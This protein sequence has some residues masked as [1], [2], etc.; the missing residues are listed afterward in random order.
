ME[1]Q[2]CHQRPA[3]VHITQYYNGEKKEMHLCEQCAQSYQSS[4]Q[5]PQFPIHNLN[6]LLGFLT[7][8]HED[9]KEIN[10]RCPNCQSPYPRIG[11]LGYVGCSEC[12]EYFASKL[13]PALRKIHGAKRH[14]G[15]IPHRAGESFRSKREIEE[16]KNKLKQLIEHEEYEEAALIRDQIRKIENKDL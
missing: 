4:F 2:K 11:E 12:Y 6:N 5:F 7:Q 15:K 9:K 16:L 3:N 13:E 14:R 1:C 8:S 10:D